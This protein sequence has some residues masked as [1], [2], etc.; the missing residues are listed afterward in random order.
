MLVVHTLYRSRSKSSIFESRLSC[1]PPSNSASRN[2]LTISDAW[3]CPID[4]AP[5]HKTFTFVCCLARFAAKT[6]WQIAAR[7]PGTL[8]AAIEG[9]TPFE[10]IKIPKSWLPLATDSPNGKAISG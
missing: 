8:L 9:P 4:Q 10:H 3:P 2:E 6:S 5:R 1:R 7:I